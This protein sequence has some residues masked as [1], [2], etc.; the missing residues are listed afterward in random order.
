MKQKQLRIENG[1][2]Y[3]Q[4]SDAPT[5]TEIRQAFNTYMAGNKVKGSDL[6]LGLAEMFSEMSWEIVPWANFTPEEARYA[7]SNNPEM[8]LI[9]SDD[10][11]DE[12]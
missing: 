9:I 1:T 4:F 3:S 5:K 10:E 6:L 2:V 7:A 12:E 8:Y 11:S